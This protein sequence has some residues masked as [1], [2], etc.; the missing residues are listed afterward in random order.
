MTINEKLR[1]YRIAH[2]LTQRELSSRIGVSD[3]SIYVW[4]SGGN[5][6]TRSM[7]LIANALGSEFDEYIKMTT[8]K[9]CGKQFYAVVHNQIK[10]DNCSESAASHK[11]QITRRERDPFNKKLAEVNQ[12]ARDAG[13]SYGQYQAMNRG[14]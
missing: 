13:M 14:C 5:I 4:E 1:E 9:I 12:M 2:K 10:C 3:H 11:P 6:T 7:V 8:C